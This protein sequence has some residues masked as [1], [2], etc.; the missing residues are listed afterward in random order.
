MVGAPARAE[1]DAVKDALA[2]IEGRASSG[3]A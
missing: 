2:A 3:E 1:P